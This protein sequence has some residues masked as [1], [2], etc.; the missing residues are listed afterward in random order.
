MLSRVGRPH[1][2]MSAMLRKTFRTDINALR[3]VAVIAV[4][5]Y[6]F[7][8]LFTPGGFVGVDIF[9]AI[10]GYLMTG[11]VIDGLETNSPLFTQ[12]KKFY[13]ARARRIIPALA[14]LL[15]VLMALGWAFLLPK[16]FHD[17]GTHVAF[18]S[19]FLSNYKFF[20]EA[21]YFDTESHEKWLLHTWSLSAEWQ[22]YL[23]YPILL[24]VIWKNLGG[25]KNL[26]TAVAA[27]GLI[28]F[29]L[30]LFTAPVEPT[31]AFFSLHTR[32][33]E[34]L[35]GG[36]IFLINP[37]T[38]P[39]W[40]RGVAEVAGLVML[41][42][43][44]LT[45]DAQK[46]WPSAVTALP[47]LGSMCILIAAQ[48]RSI[49]ARNRV[50]Q[51]IGDRSYSIY[52]WHW[53]II[54]AIRYA[55]LPSTPAIMMAGIAAS[56]IIGALSFKWIET[57]SLKQKPSAPSRL[58]SASNI[59]ALLASV[60]TAGV[61]I[62]LAHG[63]PSRIPETITNIAAGA[64]DFR[65]TQKQCTTRTGNVSPGCLITRNG[66][67]SSATVK[68]TMLGDSHADAMITALAAAMPS[69]RDAVLDLTY[70]GC[71][72]VDEFKMVASEFHEGNRCTDFL[73]WAKLR[74]EEEASDVPLVIATRASAYLQGR[75]EKII[76]GSIP[77]PSIYFTERLPASDPLFQQE[78]FNNYK[79]TICTFS[80]KRK[81]YLV[82]PT[83]EMIKNIPKTLARALMRGDTI[84]ISVSRADFDARHRLVNKMQRQIA[85]DCNVTILNPA[86]YLCNDQL[87]AST[88]Q[89]R[90][91][92]YDDDHLSEH[93]NKQL[94]PM[95]ETVLQQ[96][97]QQNIADK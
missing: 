96:N 25:R 40:V 3:A 6:H 55:D 16:E 39:A 36:M 27:L 54:V 73:K 76:T 92:Y 53:P 97:H 80:S 44:I 12:L 9:F 35:A 15:L 34:M 43:S 38:L 69:E 10:S 11:I 58:I 70:F 95:F 7:G 18:S 57:P 91:M 71:P 24:W 65:R 47:V 14:A 61:I 93:G 41:A 17:L 78:Y 5:L 88:Y 87:C 49:F 8:V 23:I 20:M 60:V 2:E 31:L 74:I 85:E 86:E 77:M 52:L 45:I 48:Q 13:L 29:G 75:N 32:A 46:I 33:W 26:L 64:E 21:G 62:R 4:T 82:A 42:A 66:V 84:P 94:V 59:T 28:S 1:T 30:C 81:T 56:I 22:F 79:R 37:N 19:T 72:V 90:P 83:P 68:A 67:A 63:F 50:L 51:W 89:G